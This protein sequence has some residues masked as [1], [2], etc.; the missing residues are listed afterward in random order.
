MD[1]DI[2]YGKLG[3]FHPHNSFYLALPDDYISP[4]WLGIL[5]SD[6]ILP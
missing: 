3:H 2:T 4:I 5:G 6:G 1:I